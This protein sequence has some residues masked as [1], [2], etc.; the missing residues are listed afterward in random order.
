MI[1][2]ATTSSTPAIGSGSYKVQVT[3]TNGCQS[4]ADPYVYGG[5]TNY[6]PGVSMGDVKIF[7][8]PAQNVVHIESPMQVRAVISG[9]DGRSVMNVAEAKDIDIS[10]LPDGI[11]MIMIYD[12]EGQKI[13]TD[14]LVKAAN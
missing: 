8:N 13:K 12:T 1:A 14:K 10:N 3:D 2:G 11:Y 4:F 5:G 9:I 6:V 7:P